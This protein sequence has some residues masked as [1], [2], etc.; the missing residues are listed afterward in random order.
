MGLLTI[1]V[2]FFVTLTKSNLARKG[3]IS[4]HSLWSLLKGGQDLKEGAKA[5]TTEDTDYWLVRQGL[6]M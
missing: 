1:L 5:E 6:S 3:F 2:C 4:S